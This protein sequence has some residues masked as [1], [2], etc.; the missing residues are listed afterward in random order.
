MKGKLLIV[1]TAL[2]LVIG[3]SACGG[4]EGNPFQ[5]PA[6]HYPAFSNHEFSQGFQDANPNGFWYGRTDACNGV[7]YVPGQLDYRN[8]NGV[9]YEIQYEIDYEVTYYGDFV[10]PYGSKYDP[11]YNLGLFRGYQRGYDA[12]EAERR[13]GNWWESPA[14]YCYG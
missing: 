12:G 8:V 3:L 13:F 10:T 6:N 5:P 1:I 7:P 11:G 2:S 4:N 9:P 14:V